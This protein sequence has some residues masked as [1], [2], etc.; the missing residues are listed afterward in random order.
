MKLVSDLMYSVSGILSGLNLDNVTDLYGCFERAAR[1]LVQKAKIP[2]TQGTQ[3]ILLYNGVTDYLID[4]SIFGTSILDIRPQGISRNSNDFVFKKFGDDFDREK[5]L[6]RIGTIATFDYSNGT[7]II[8][9]VSNRTIQRV[10]LDTMTSITGWTYNA[11]VTNVIADSS[12]YY[13][14]PASIRFN[15]AASGSP[16]YLEKTLT[17][18]IN[19]NTYQGTGVGFLAIELPTTDFTSFELRIGSDSSNYY[20]VTNT[21]G[22]TGNVT[23]EFMLVAF[24]LSLATT[25]GSPDI[26]KIKYLRVVLN[27]NGTAQTNVRIGGL[28]ISLPSPAQVL[29]SSAGFFRVGDVVSQSITDPSNEIILSDPAYTLYQY[30]SA[31]AILQNT[32]GANNDSATARIDGI[33]NSSYTR[34]GKI[35]SLGLYDMYRS[36]NPSAVLRQSGSWYSNDTGY[37]NRSNC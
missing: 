22:F 18:S 31:L 33:L 35:L 8:R 27:Y 10:V 7:P 4:E 1:V 20:T 6:N 16:G 25:V 9:I 36:E 28:F 5:Q 34:T 13:Q 19:L 11:S 12:F 17:N 14:Q 37:D 30:E 24:D 3:N 26:T 23:N 32:G 15:L 2:E 21:V 29:Y